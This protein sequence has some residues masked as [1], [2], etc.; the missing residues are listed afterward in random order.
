MRLRQWLADWWERLRREV[1]PGGSSARVEVEAL[2]AYSVRK[3]SRR[4]RLLSSF[5]KP[6]CA[7]GSSVYRTSKKKRR[8]LHSPAVI[9][10]ETMNAPEILACPRRHCW[11][12]FAG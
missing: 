7:R 6:H 3:A 9:L 8:V 5:A 12:S 11:I 1:S 10:R 4:A 2:P